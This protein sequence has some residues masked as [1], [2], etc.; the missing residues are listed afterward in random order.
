MRILTL[1]CWCGRLIDDLLPF[2]AR[3]A[4]HV[5]AFLFQEVL[6]AHQSKVDAR[7]P[8]MTG[9]RGDLFIGLMRALPDH[10]GIFARWPESDRM[11][12]AIFVRRSIPLLDAREHLVYEPEQPKEEGQIVFSPRKLQ[13]VTVPFKGERLLIANL[14][15]LWD[16]GPKTDTP[17][18]IEQAKRVRMVMDMHRGPKV[19]AGDFNLL[20]GTESMHIMREAKV[21]LVQEHRVTSTRTPLYR[22]YNDPSEPNFADYILCSPDLTATAFEVLPD[23]VSDHCPLYAELA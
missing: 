23:L 10:L 13:T 6:D 2:V 18:R 8:K 22:H 1:N 4:E 20:P 12:T 17:D 11:S 16:N 21:D 7:H 14:H 9:L 15:G 3:Q 5:D 19:L